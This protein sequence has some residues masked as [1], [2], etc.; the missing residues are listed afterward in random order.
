MQIKDLKLCKHEIPW[1]DSIMIIIRMVSYIFY[2]CAT[3][4]RPQ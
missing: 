1:A 4:V 2:R 3:N